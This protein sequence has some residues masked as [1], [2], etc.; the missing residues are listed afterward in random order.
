MSKE[1]RFCDCCGLKKSI[2]F[3]P[4][5]SNKR[6]VKGAIIMRLKT[7][8]DC[9]AKPDKVKMAKV[10]YDFLKGKYSIEDI[11]KKHNTNHSYVHRVS[12]KY[13]DNSKPV[14]FTIH[15]E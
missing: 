12:S 8:S 14:K 5:R 15:G 3:Y 6:K 7:C 10:L 2:G 1:F 11:A 9:M 4:K 13:L